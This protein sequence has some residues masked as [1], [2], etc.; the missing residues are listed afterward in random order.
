MHL[1]QGLSKHQE[2][3]DKSDQ[4]YCCFRNLLDAL[5]GRFRNIDF[6][7]FIWNIGEQSSLSKEWEINVSI[8]IYIVRGNFPNNW[9]FVSFSSEQ[10]KITF[11]S[12]KVV[13]IFNDMCPAKKKYDTFF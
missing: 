13:C 5:K 9:N 11:D 3:V 10:E 2:T 4:I 8:C 1:D 7:C 12:K 6:I